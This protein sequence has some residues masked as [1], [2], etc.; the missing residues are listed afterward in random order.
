MHVLAHGGAGGPPRGTT[1]RQ[2]VIDD[3]VTHGLE[4]SNPLDAVVRAVNILEDSPRFNAGR[5]GTLQTDGRQRMDAGV[6][7]SDGRVGA[8]CNVPG[9]V[10]TV[11]LARF[12]HSE[13][14]H[15]LLGP[16]GAR[17]VGDHLGVDLNVDLI[18]EKQQSRFDELDIPGDFEGQLGFVNERFGLP[19]TDDVALDTVGA[20]ATDGDRL[21]AA[22][23]T[24]GRWVALA[25]RIGD[26]PQVGGGFFCS[27]VAAVSTTGSGEDIARATLAREV[28]RLIAD[29]FS[30]QVA[31]IEAV[32]EFEGR[33]DG[34]AGVIAID[35]DGEIGSA[36]NTAAMQTAVAS[37]Q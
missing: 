12:V 25:G 34:S 20:V 16:E 7:T 4:G 5:G 14:P 15:I 26:V 27:E 29:G 33:T 6:M 36:Y 11:D 35:R 37:D 8:V 28:E 22:T 24:G 21:A 13:T 19:T 1:E 23:S 31:T 32:A 17:A 2:A 9:V 3:A 30:P 10:R 18:T